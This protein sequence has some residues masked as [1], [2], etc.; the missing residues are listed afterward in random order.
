M[1]YWIDMRKSVIMLFFAVAVVTLGGCDFL[2]RAAGRPTSDQIDARRTEIL[3]AE[4][5]REAAEKMRMD[6]LLREQKIV[7]DSLDALQAIEDQGVVV[8]ERAR[9]G[10][11]I[12]T[13]LESRYYIIV[14][15][16]LNSTNANMLIDKV[17]SLGYAPQL[18]RFRSGMIAVGLCPVN[19]VADAW[20]SLTAVKAE[21]FCPA[22]A[23]ILLNE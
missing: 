16:F 7:Q 22:D 11:V 10:G 6:S 23:W 13:E 14:G 18:I 21:S 8:A 5:A 17:T 12:S 20:A 2:R 9:L 15:S 4:A 19:K 3:Q 1:Q